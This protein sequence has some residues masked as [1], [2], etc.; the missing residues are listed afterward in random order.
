MRIIDNKYDFYDYLQDYTDVIVFDRR[1]SFYLTKEMICREIN[2]FWGWGDGRKYM[3]IQCGATLWLFF[4]KTTCQ[5]IDGW[6]KTVDCEFELVDY[7]K[8]YDKPNKLLDIHLINFRYM[9]GIN[10]YKNEDMRAAINHNDLYDDKKINHYIKYID[11]KGGYK[12][13]ESDIPILT[14]A[15]LGSVINPIDMFCAI[16]EYFSIEKTKTETT[17]PKGA[18]NDDKIVMH[19]FDTKSS[20]RGKF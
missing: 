10:G 2:K 14:T 16:E 5:K 11:H 7:W 8:N 6:E 1:G 4:L 20:F 3:Y 17:E 18:T 15:G 13:E 12:R 9:V 19:G